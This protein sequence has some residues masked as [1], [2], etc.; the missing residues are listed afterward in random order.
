ME[1]VAKAN[2]GVVCHHDHSVS[3]YSTD[4][5]KDADVCYPN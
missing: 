1:G 3:G 2:N 4:C 5:Y